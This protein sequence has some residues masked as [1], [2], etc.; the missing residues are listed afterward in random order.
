MMQIETSGKKNETS[1]AD[2][3]SNLGGKKVTQE[4]TNG[5]GINSTGRAARGA[6]S[7]HER[8]ILQFS[9]AF[10]LLILLSSNVSAFGLRP[11]LNRIDF[12]PG[13]TTEGQ[14]VVLTT[15][16]EVG[17]ARLIADGELAKYIT[18]PSEYI[19]LGQETSIPYSITLPEKLSP[20]QHIGKILIEEDIEAPEGALTAKIQLAFTIY[21]NVAI[22]EKHIRATI[23]IKVE[24]NALGVTTKVKNIGSL[25]VANVAP[26]ITI[27][28]PT[29][30]IASVDMIAKPLEI[31]ESADFTQQIPINNLKNGIYTATA[32]IAYDEGTLIITKEFSVGVPLASISRSDTT[33]KAGEI[34]AFTFDV[35]SDWN[36]QLNG[37]TASVAVSQDGERKASFASEKFDLAPRDNV[38]IKTH[39]DATKL[40]A[41]TYDAAI[42]L[43]YPDGSAMNEFKIDLL[44]TTKKGWFGPG[45]FAIIVFNALIAIYVITRI[46]LRKP[47]LPKSGLE[48]YVANARAKGYSTE[49]IRQLLMKAGWPIIKI[50]ESLR[51]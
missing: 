31:A 1:Y 23:D 49:Q 26:Q 13:Q 30:T 45:L 8:R 50:K 20:G 19:K 14:F 35:Q 44:D 12:S 42:T 4:R 22:P 48:E 2:E 27:S 29:G 32:A 36:S 9:F 40:T 34:N 41:G 17:Q 39:F 21:V 15:P 43:T 18:L 47:N 46:V 51:K 6:Q 38:G 28:N 10:L 5:N 33:F 37:V 7:G 3:R 11:T 25:G 16:E 24:E